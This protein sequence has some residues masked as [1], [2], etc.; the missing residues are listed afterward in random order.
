MR[1]HGLSCSL[2]AELPLSYF[3]SSTRHPDLDIA[4]LEGLPVNRINKLL[5]VASALTLAHQP[6]LG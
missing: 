5:I 4:M 1:R 2:P 3:L 6:F